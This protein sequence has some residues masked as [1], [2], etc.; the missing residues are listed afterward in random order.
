MATPGRSH[1]HSTSIDFGSPD[2][3][4]AQQST[5]HSSRR[6]LRHKASFSLPEI[7]PVDWDDVRRSFADC[8]EQDDN[9]GIDLPP[10]PANYAPPELSRVTEHTEH[11]GNESTLM[12]ETMADMGSTI[13][14]LGSTPHSTK[15]SR[16]DLTEHAPILLNIDRIGENTLNH[17]FRTVGS[18]EEGML[19]EME[20]VMEMDTPT[21]TEFVI[22]PPPESYADS[23]RDSRASQ[24]T[25][26]SMDEDIPP[27]PAIRGYSTGWTTSDVTASDQFMDADEVYPAPTVRDSDLAQHL[28]EIRESPHVPFPA[29]S[30]P[31]PP[32]LHVSTSVPNFSRPQASRQITSAHPPVNVRADLRAL[33]ARKS[34][35]TM[36]SDSTEFTTTTATTSTPS[37]VRVQQ[38]FHISKKELDRVKA[39]NER[40]E[41]V[42][43]KSSQGQYE[44]IVA[45]GKDAEKTTKGLRPLQLVSKRDSNR[46]SAE[47]A[48]A[49]TSK[50]VS[51]LQ[52]ST[53]QNSQR[54]STTERAAKS[55]AGT[56]KMS[57]GSGKENARA[58][59]KGSKMSSSSGGG[60]QGLRA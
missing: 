28:S 3:H 9:A 54:R 4:D 23:G 12:R 24:R 60:V 30:H 22:S 46:F 11:E 35:E 17:S 2:F 44:S 29:L 27:V 1:G 10:I 49:P 55:S 52:E 21:R 36:R 45:A 8:G 57:T 25:A 19:E 50:R 16:M 31:H 40:R 47:I 53:S 59:K 7:N 56:G 58:A 41:A 51:A 18:E 20:R 5:P 33:R 14:A 26:R 39:L 38:N 42:R 48:S 37:P 15:S 43:S 13:L 32:P 6:R 34:T